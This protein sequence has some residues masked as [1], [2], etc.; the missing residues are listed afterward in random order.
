MHALMLFFLLAAAPPLKL[1]DKVPPI[2]RN[3]TQGTAAVRYDKDNV[4][5]AACYKRP[6]KC[7][8]GTAY[9]TGACVCEK[10]RMPL[11]DQDEVVVGCS[12]KAADKME[13]KP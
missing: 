7:A 3:C 2:T 9:G 4:E 1:W 5:H 8:D 13:A 6:L 12:A 11:L 10:D